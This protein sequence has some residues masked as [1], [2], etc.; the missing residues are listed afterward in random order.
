MQR[1]EF[2][3]RAALAACIALALSGCGMIGESRGT[4]GGETVELS[5]AQE[6][7]PVQTAAR[8]SGNVRVNDDGSVAVKVS[9]SG[10]T[11]TAA[12][13]HQAAAGANGPVIVPLAKA[14]ETEFISPPGFKMSPDHIKAYRAGN[15]YINVHSAKHPGGEIRGQLKGR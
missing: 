6:V 5:G 4:G 1:F 11:A 15:T 8:G 9:I 13:I 3:R 2:T 12:H 7:P 10:M 14:S